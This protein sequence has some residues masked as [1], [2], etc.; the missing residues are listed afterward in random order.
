MTKSPW[1]QTASRIIREVMKNNPD[2][3]RKKL[4]RLIS[5]AYPFGERRMHPYKIWCD[6]VKVQLGTKKRK[7]RGEVNDPKQIDLL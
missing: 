4:K 5:E 2:A 1:R 3:D 6:E 7:H